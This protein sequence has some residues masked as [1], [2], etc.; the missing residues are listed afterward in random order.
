[1]NDQTKKPNVGS[2]SDMM[3]ASEKVIEK[4]ENQTKDIKNERSLERKNVSTNE[5]VTERLM[6]HHSFDVFVDQLISLDQIRTDTYQESGK[7][8]KIY[9]LVQEALDE[10]IKSHKKERKNE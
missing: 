7:K 8:P 10:Y 5:R 3:E 1:M 6:K 9:T 4:K 2:F